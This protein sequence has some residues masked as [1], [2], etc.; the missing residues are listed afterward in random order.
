MRPKQAEKFIE[1]WVANRI[2]GKKLEKNLVPDEYKQNDNGDLWVGDTFEFG[3]NNIELKC[4]FSTES[5]IRCKQFR[6]YENVPWYLIYRA[7]NIDHHE[8]FLLTK[9]QLVNE[10]IN[11]ARVSGKSAL[12]SSQGSG[13]ISKFNNDQKIDRLQRNL[14]KEYQDKLSWGFNPK[15]E[16]EYYEYFKDTYLV[17]P[18]QVKYLIN[19]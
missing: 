5:D 12:G 19:N 17:N 10:I 8:M 11:R 16:K 7:W 2:G 6:F 13:I 15:T 1:G 9:E 3:K 14:T 18:D 4:S